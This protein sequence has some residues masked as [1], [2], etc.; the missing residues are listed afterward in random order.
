[1]ALDGLK[2][3]EIYFFGMS[4]K[5]KNKLKADRGNVFQK[6]LILTGKE[7]DIFIKVTELFFG[8]QIRSEA[9]TFCQ[10]V[11]PGVTNAWL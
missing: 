9:K 10:E 2:E 1:M 7:L 6:H 3:R 5:K 11:R 4:K 8:P